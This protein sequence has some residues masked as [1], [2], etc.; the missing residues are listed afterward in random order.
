[1][2]ERKS[3]ITLLAIFILSALSIFLA[4][5]LQFDYNFENFFP[6]NDPDTEYY[7]F[8]RDQFQTDNDFVVIGLVNDEGIFDAGFLKKV[9]SLK[10]E[11]QGIKDVVAVSSPTDLKDYKRDPLIGQ[12]FSRPLLRFDQPEF[13]PLDSAYIYSG[14]D[15]VGSF[16]S[17]DA[18]ALLV[19]I[20]HTEFL[21]K[22]G[23][24]TLSVNLQAVVKQAGFDESHVVGRAIGQEYYV[25][26][27][28]TELMI[29]VSLSIL[30]VILFLILSFRS[31]WGVWVPIMVVLLSIIWTLAL[32]QLTGK[33]IDLMLTILPTILF[34]VGMS[35][36]VHIVSRFFEEMRSGRTKYEAV[37]IAFKEI[38][39]ATFLTSLTTAIGFLTLLSSSIR[40]LSEFG[41][42][43]A[44]GVFIAFVL[45][46]T[47]LPAVLMLSKPPSILQKRPEQLFWNRFLL[48]GFSFTIRNRKGILIAFGLVGIVSFW[49][50]RQVEVNN[51]I[52]EDL[53]D[54]DP[55]KEEFRFFEENFSGA[56]PFELSITLAHD[57][58][59]AFDKPV[60]DQITLIDDYLESTYGVGELISPAKIVKTAYRTYMGGNRDFFRIPDRQSDIDRLQSLIQRNELSEFLGYYVNEEQGLL[61]STGKLD[62]LG[63]KIFLSKDSTFR[64]WAEANVNPNLLKLKITGTASLIDSNN[65]YLATNLIEGLG[66]AFLVIALIAGLMFKSLKMVVIS[67]IPNVFPLLMIG[68]IMG[69]SGIDLKVSTSIIFTIAFGIAVDDTIH[70][71]SKLRLQLGTGKSLLYSLKRSYISTG[72]AI[73]LTTIILC[74]GFLT[75]ISSDFLGTF[76]VGL[77]ISL[78]LLFAV[79]SDL[80]LLPVLVILFFKPG[81][82]RAKE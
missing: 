81:S 16:F 54:G 64:A 37:R 82:Y 45:A 62:D 35:D 58:L 79:I 14:G 41:L 31:F 42:Y 46:F 65:K 70:F 18:K 7:K 20:R 13:L 77:L 19:Q 4:S 2:Y 73:I 51:Y 53:K 25:N 30:L 61:R 36:V 78:T 34:V 10:L 15:Y 44:A 71:V 28:Q 5:R 32:M 9:D 50:I 40:P 48:H 75:L 66:I 17:E 38:G 76:Y 80:L 57:S 27:M 23:C 1:M 8:F 6:E 47:L 67:L 59:N 56:R 12:V 72:K 60:L 11:L 24:D 22:E 55:L 69:F 3:R 52:L 74:G 39:L 29:F 21:S 43:T 33:R 26:L 49:G 68:G 63:S